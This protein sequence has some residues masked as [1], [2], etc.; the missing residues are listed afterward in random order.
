MA[1]DPSSGWSKYSDITVGSPSSD[2]QM[3]IDLRRGG[4]HLNN[5]PANGIL[6]D[7]YGTGDNG[8][9]YSDMRDVQINST[10]DPTTGTRLPQWTEEVDSGVKRIFWVKT[11]GAEHIYIFV[12]NSGASEYSNGGATFPDFFDALDNITSFNANWTKLRGDDASEDTPSFY[13]KTMIKIPDTSTTVGIEGNTQYE[14]SIS[15]PTSSKFVVHIGMASDTNTYTQTRFMSANDNEIARLF[16]NRGSYNYHSIYTTAHHGFGSGAV[17]EVVSFDVYFDPSNRQILKVIASDGSSYTT[18]LSYAYAEDLSKI[19]L[20]SLG[21]RSTGNSWYSNLFVRKYIDSEP[22]FTNFGAWTD[23][24]GGYAD[25]GIRYYDGT[26]VQAISMCSDETT[27]ALRFYDGTNVK[28][29]PLVDIN[30]ANA[31]PIRVYTGTEV[32]ALRKQ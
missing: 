28:Y 16:L 7:E 19:I 24:G 21:D 2:Y 13:N 8:C 22:S 17:N 32:K 27:S 3:R 14:Q 31:S 4:S 20:H 9:Y 10:D 18:T 15:F 5:D 29:I 23:V 26:A 1:L 6:Y 11:N 12:G 25:S 30:D